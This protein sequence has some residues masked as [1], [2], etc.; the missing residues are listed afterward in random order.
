M[1]ERACEELLRAARA[2]DENAFRAAVGTL[3]A[4]ITRYV[5]SLLRGELGRLA[6][7]VRCDAGDL[8]SAVVE[9]LLKAD[10]HGSDA[11]PRATVLRWIKTAA[12]NHLFDEKRKARR[13][14][15]SIDDVDE[16]ASSAPDA[17]ELLAA[18]HL[19]GALTNLLASFYPSGVPLFEHEADGG[20]ADDESLADELGITVANLQA[21]RTRMR[22]YVRA[23]VALRHEP[24]ADDEVARAMSVPLTPETRR[25]IANVRHHLASRGRK[26]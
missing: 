9:K 18:E 2:G 20:G 19:R 11:T 6:R 15:S 24:R 8:A 26:R 12:R 5:E 4:D 17:D 23:Y 7:E 13:Q 21:R 14:E 25:I 22:K 10:L 3:H 16:P 1:D